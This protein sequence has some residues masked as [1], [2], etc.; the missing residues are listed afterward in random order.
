MCLAD[1]TLTNDEQRPTAPRVGIREAG[2]ERREL[3]GAA[4]ER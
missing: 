1:S 4:D 2:G 3:R